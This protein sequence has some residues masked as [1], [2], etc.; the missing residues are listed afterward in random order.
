MSIAKMFNCAIIIFAKTLYA[1][2]AQLVEQQIR[3]L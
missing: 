3:N 2:I 1:I